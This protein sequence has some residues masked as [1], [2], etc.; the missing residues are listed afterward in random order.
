M[1]YLTVCTRNEYGLRTRG[2]YMCLQHWVLLPT[3][4]KWREGLHRGGDRGPFQTERRD[5]IGNVPLCGVCSRLWHL[6]RRLTLPS[7]TKQSFAVFTHCTW[8]SHCGRNHMHCYNYILVQNRTG[9][10]ETHEINPDYHYLFFIY[11]F[12][13]EAGMAEGF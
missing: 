2:V 5:R 3:K 10:F 4:D 6:C 8:P 9:E 11:L 1:S 12:L 13:L 7:P